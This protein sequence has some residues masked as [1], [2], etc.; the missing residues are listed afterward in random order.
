FEGHA[1]PYKKNI[2][3]LG[4]KSVLGPKSSISDSPVVKEAFA[5]EKVAAE[6]AAA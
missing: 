6:P 1:H 5:K 4:G 3:K 2:L